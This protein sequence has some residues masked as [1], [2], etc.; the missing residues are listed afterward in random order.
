MCF[1]IGHTAKNLFF[2]LSLIISLIVGALAAMGDSTIFGFMKALPSKCYVGYSAG[3]GLSG[4]VGS[5]LPI[6]TTIMG[7]DMKWVSF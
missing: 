1:S 6:F 3:T 5:L 4:I 2:T 7:F